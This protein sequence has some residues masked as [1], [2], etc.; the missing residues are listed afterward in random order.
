MNGFITGLL[1]TLGVIIAIIIVFLI[2][3]V[4]GTKII[5]SIANM[6]SNIFKKGD[7]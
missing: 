2:I 4:C 5:C 1:F 7:K 6:I 3:A